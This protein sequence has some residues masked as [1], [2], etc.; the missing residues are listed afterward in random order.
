AIAAGN[1]AVIKPSAYSPASSAIIANIIS[2]VFPEEYVAVVEGGREVNSD[3]LKLKFD[4]IF[5]T[6]SKTVG[7]LVMKSAAEHL[8]PVTLE[9]GGKSP[10][11]VTGDADMKVTADRIAF[12]K[13]LNCGQTCVAPDY[14]LVH[15]DAEEEFVERLSESVRKMFGESPLKNESYCKIINRKHFDRLV[16]ILDEIRLNGLGKSISGGETDSSNGKISPAIVR[17]GSYSNTKVN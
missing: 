13:F 12:G 6:G 10:A 16:G 17:L 1:T 7:K 4:Y 5:F 8:T 3:L 15:K 11:I 2:R 14:I 9:L